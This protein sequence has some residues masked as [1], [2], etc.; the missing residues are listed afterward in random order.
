MKI[1]KRNT[2]YSLGKGKE[3]WFIFERNVQRDEYNNSLCE[4]LSI[5]IHTKEVYCNRTGKQTFGIKRYLKLV[6]R[7]ENIFSLSSLRDY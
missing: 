6:L 2:S 3:N 5:N 4:S 1:T 7:I